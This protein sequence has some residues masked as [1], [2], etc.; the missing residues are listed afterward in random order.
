MNQ[1]RWERWGAASGFAA[2]LAGAAAVAFERGPVSASDPAGEIA[3][4]FAD[5][6]AAL[7]AQGL[8]FLIGGGIF[9]WFVGSLCSF[10][11][12]AEGGTGRVSMVAFGAGI[13]SA[14]ITMV[15]LAFQIGLATAPGGELQ[16]A[17]VGVMGTLF[18]AANFPLAVMLVA[19]AEVSFRARAF[20]AWLGWLSLAA[21][22]AQLVPSFGLILDSGPLA[23][24][25]WLAGYLPYPL[26]VAWLA[27]ATVVMVR[28]IGKPPVT[29]AMPA[30]PEEFIAHTRQHA[31]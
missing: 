10:L 12:R 9:L 8:L 19:V 5:N 11:I 24:D 16:P 6:A 22:A 13:A 25:G 30:T 3:D 1:T 14:M 26:Y 21:S 7:R 28:R 15:A 20:P 18:T 29:S 17:L 2:L 27:S 31:S 23:P 4:Y